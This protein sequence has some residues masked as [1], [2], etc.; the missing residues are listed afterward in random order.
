MRMEELSESRYVKNTDSVEKYLLNVVKEYFKN[1]SNVAS[2][3]SREYIIKKA[4]KRMKE[5][6]T[7]EGI[8]V[9]SVALPDDV[10]PRTGAVVITLQDLHG[11]PEITTK[12]SAF[13][14]HQTGVK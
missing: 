7:F 14:V 2:T 12:Y 10:T 13:N 4:V 11:E 9:L 3:T 8:G 6:I 5:E 1:N